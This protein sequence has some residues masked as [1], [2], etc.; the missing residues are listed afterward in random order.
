M[1]KLKIYCFALFLFLSIDLIW[2]TWSGPQLYQIE[3][4]HLLADKPKLIPALLFFSLYIF[5]LGVFVI[6][7]SLKRDEMST[8]TVAVLGALFGATAYATF[9]LTNLALIKNYSLKVAVIDIVWGALLSAIVSVCTYKFA[10]YLL[11]H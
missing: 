4:G 6:F 8:W 9:D 7:P 3:I 5:S 10:N 1:K 2:M 11:K